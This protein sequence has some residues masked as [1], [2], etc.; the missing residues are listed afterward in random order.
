MVNRLASQPSSLINPF[1]NPSINLGPSGLLGHA[2][3]ALAPT[4]LEEIWDDKPANG[5]EPMAFAL[6]KRCS[7]A[8]LSRPGR[9]AQEALYRSPSAQSSN[10]QR[11]WQPVLASSWVTWLSTVRGLSTNAAAMPLLVW[12]RRNSPSTRCSAGVR[13]LRGSKNQEHA[14]SAMA[15]MRVASAFPHPQRDDLD[16]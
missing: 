11:L 10:W 2:A 3:K 9:E 7:T 13:G 12:P 8:E 16:A 14:G 15:G 6:Q 5:F 4:A 1:I